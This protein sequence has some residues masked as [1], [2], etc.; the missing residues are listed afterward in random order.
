MRAFPQGTGPILPTTISAA[1]APVTTSASSESRMRIMSLFDARHEAADERGQCEQ[2]KSAATREEC[3]VQKLR[4]HRG[5]VGAAHAARSRAA[6]RLPQRG[7]EKPDAHRLAGKARGREL[8]HGAEPDR[9]EE[10]FRDRVQEAGRAQPQPR[11][12]PTEKDE[13]A[14]KCVT[15][16]PPRA[17][18]GRWP[19]SWRAKAANRAAQGRSRHW[20]PARRG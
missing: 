20:R 3:D 1:E 8:R 17:G 5:G 13:R 18:A 14:A 4:G 9:A 7:G 11:D 19:F 10:K 2:D 12:F 6:R 15:K 16:K